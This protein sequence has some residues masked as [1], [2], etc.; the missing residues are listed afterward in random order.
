M[1]QLEAEAKAL[2][3]GDLKAQIKRIQVSSEWIIYEERV[4][5]LVISYLR[6]LG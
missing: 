3:A 6:H 1:N 4:K 5:S 2:P